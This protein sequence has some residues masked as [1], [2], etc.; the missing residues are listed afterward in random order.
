MDNVSSS[1]LIVGRW[2]DTMDVN[3]IYNSGDAMFDFYNHAHGY[4]V[5][6]P[7]SN[8]DTINGDVYRANFT[9]NELRTSFGPTTDPHPYLTDGTPETSFEITDIRE[10]GSTLSFHVHFLNVGI[11]EQESD[12][13]RIY[14]NPASDQLYVEGSDIQSLSLCDLLGKT[15]CTLSGSQNSINISTLPS[16]VY[17]LRVTT[18]SGI[19]TKKIVKK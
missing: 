5:F 9:Q 7:G 18:S 17:W 6:R 13:L 8:V 10:E 11:A 16:G 1:G 19:V 4:W 3:D 15:I 2:V 12:R 14:P